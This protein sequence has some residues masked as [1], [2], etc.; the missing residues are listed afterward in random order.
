MHKKW[1]FNW[2]FYS[3]YACDLFTM[4]VIKYNS[5]TAWLLEVYDADEGSQE[6]VNYLT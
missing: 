3:I 1:Y 5:N 4:E 6:M 2:S